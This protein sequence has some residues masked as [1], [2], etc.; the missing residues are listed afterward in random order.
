M[1]HDRKLSYRREDAM[2]PIGLA[3]IAAGCRGPNIVRTAVATP[4]FRLQWLVQ[5]HVGVLLARLS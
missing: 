1:T 3:V 2:P 5:P 4:A